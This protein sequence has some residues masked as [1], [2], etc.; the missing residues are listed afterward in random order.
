MD[1]QQRKIS[2]DPPDQPEL[3]HQPVHPGD[4][5]ETRHIQ[6][7]ADLVT[8]LARREHRLRPRTPMP[9]PGMPGRDP[10]P[11]ARHVP[12]TLL[13]RYLLHQKG[14]SFGVVLRALPPRR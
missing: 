1:L 13:L 9:G 6:V 14:L 2:V 7:G 11:T 12:P 4:P 10:A 8:D 3:G 5:T